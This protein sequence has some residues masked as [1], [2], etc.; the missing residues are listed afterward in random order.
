MLFHEMCI[1]SN[2]SSSATI[3]P[4]LLTFVQG[5]Q[6]PLDLVTGVGAEA[7]AAMEVADRIH[8]LM[9]HAREC[10]KRV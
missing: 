5:V 3:S 6:E 4:N 2:A 9:G 10:V 7:P 1:N 8:R